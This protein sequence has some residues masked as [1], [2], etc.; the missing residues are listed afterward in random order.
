MEKV[1]Y[2]AGGCF[3]GIEHLMQSIDGVIDATSGY[4]NGSKKEDASYK[5]VCTGNTGFKETVRVTYD[6]LKV[7]L[8]LILSA[9]FYVIHPEQKNRQGND[10]G[11]QYQ[12]G[13]YYVDEE[14]KKTV[15]RLYELEKSRHEKFYVEKGELVN[16]FEAEEYHQNYLEKNPNGYC[17][18]PF[19]EIAIFK[20]LKIDPGK[21]LRP[22]EEKIRE[23][24]ER[25]NE[26]V[27]ASS[28]M[29]DYLRESGRI[30]IPE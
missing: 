15:E 29:W 5:T 17:H 28:Y 9:Y 10:I 3:W 2:L 24:L 30:T 12:T 4:A 23:K 26:G 22:S 7:S 11:T 6:P 18:I 14:S 16:F 1:I 19:D 13:I 25:W 20:K 8:D 27:Y 21:Y